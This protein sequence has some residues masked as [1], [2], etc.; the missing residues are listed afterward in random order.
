MSAPIRASDIV[1][2]RHAGR[3]GVAWLVE[4]FAMFRRAPL[5]WTTLMI[6]YV[7]FMYVAAIV[8]ALGF[9]FLVLRPVLAV[10]LL[11]AAWT[12]ERGGRPRLAHLFQGFRANLRALLALGGLYIAGIT[13]GILA[14]VLFDGGTLLSL[15]SQDPASSTAATEALLKSGA[16][17]RSMLLAVVLSLP[18]VLAMW[19]APALVVF[20]DASPWTALGASL[21]ATV[22]NWAPIVMYGLA[23]AL[24][25]LVLPML[26]VMGLRLAFPG[27]MAKDALQLAYFAYWLVISATL[28]ISDY[29]GYRDVFHAGETLAPIEDRSK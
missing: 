6:V 12:Q 19:F 28:H 20:Q 29:I 7:M 15:V 14:T 21:R 8:P 22:A 23:V 3:R 16:L 24:V 10:G 4:A 9:V 27:E 18:T 13:L 2:T 1:F 17:Q 26:V 25:G 5:A 11:A